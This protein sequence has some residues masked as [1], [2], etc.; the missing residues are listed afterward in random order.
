MPVTD[1]FSAIAQPM[2]PPAAAPPAADPFAAIAQPAGTPPQPKAGGLGGWVSRNVSGEGSDE[3]YGSPVAAGFIKSGGQMLGSILDLIHGTYVKPLQFPG[4]PAPTTPATPAVDHIKDAA[5]W[6]HQGSQPEGFWENVGAVG[7]QVLE[8]LGTDG[9]L[10]MV[11]GGAKAA[12]TV[13]RAAETAEHL[14]QAQQVTQTLAKNPKLAG[15]VAIGAKAAK[16]ATMMGVQTYAHTEDPIQALKGAGIGGTLGTVGGAAGRLLQKIRPKTVEIAGEEIPALASQVNEAGVP[17]DTGAQGAPVIQEAQQQAAQRVIQN[18]ARQA[19]VRAIEGI[20]ATRPAGAVV[21]DT[22]RML[23]A[24][25][26]AKPFTFTLEGPGTVEGTTGEIAHPAAKT[27]Q[28]AFKPPRYTT[29]SAERPAVEGIEGSTGADIGTSTP[30]EG[31]QDVARGGGNLETKD[32]REAA[33]WMQQLE[34]IQ[35]S[36]DHGKLSATQQTAIETQRQSLEQQLGLYHASPYAQRFGQADAMAAAEHVR[37][38]GDAA[39][40]TRLPAEPVYQTMDRVSGGEFNKLRSSAGKAAAIMRN[41]TS[42]EAGDAAE[43][44]FAEANDK[45]NELML[46]HAD[47]VSRPDYLAAKNAWRQASRLQEL[48]ARFEAMTNGI[49]TEE[50]DQGFTRVMTG[51]TRAFE[52]YLSKGTN[53][54]QIEEL[55]GSEGIRNLK[56]LTQLLSKANTARA[57]NEVIK[58]TFLELGRHAR[59]GGVG[60][61]VGGAVAHYM[62]VPWYEGMMAGAGVAEGMRAVLRDAATNPRIGNMVDWAARNGLDPRHYA[63]LIARTIAEPMQEQPDQEEG[64]PQ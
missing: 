33:N 34:D 1:P 51:N 13:G 36:P 18:T 20:N 39:A 32:P 40:Q 53:R 64:L 45:I 48:H 37:T 21:Q 35:A 27:P 3:A 52:R 54:A 2:T 63:P 25:E 28:A 46:R 24:P 4:Q 31:A 47:Q 59:V 38:W 11:G 8:Y 29:S 15:L 22:A 62:G 57:T 41:P 14:R 50:T 12:T 56:Q 10:K 44:R 49:T 60:G 55:I 5:D 19:T 6:L 43:E 61:A 42:I 7:E 58:N 23:P 16:D 9:L 30:R 17:N 26:G